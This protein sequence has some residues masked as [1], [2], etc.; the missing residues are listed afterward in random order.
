MLSIHQ[1][2]VVRAARRPAPLHGRSHARREH[3][4]VQDLRSGALICSRWSLPADACCRAAG[5]AALAAAPA[6]PGLL[7]YSVFG[8]LGGGP[9]LLQLSL[10]NSTGARDTYVARANAASPASTDPRLRGCAPQWIECA[11]PELAYLHDASRPATCLV[12]IRQPLVRA[13]RALAAD[14]ID[15]V[16]AALSDPGGA[17]EGLRSATFAVSDRGDVVLILAEWTSLEAHEQSL[18][19]HDGGIGSSRRWRAVRQHAGIRA[20]HE[21][22][23]FELLG[24]VE[25]G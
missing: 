10:W 14:W 15:S 20:E 2:V 22:R 23:R 3:F 7:R 4:G 24:S 17:P 8:E 1:S 11:R 16:A 12:V 9:G 19:N 6:T 25:A 13:D 21:V 5:S 18:R